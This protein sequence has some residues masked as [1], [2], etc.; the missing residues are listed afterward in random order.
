MLYGEGGWLAVEKPHKKGVWDQE[1]K[2]FTFI[3][4]KNL[5]LHLKVVENKINLRYLIYKFY[6]CCKYVFYFISMK[7]IRELSKKRVQFLF[8][9]HDL[10]NVNVRIERIKKSSEFFSFVSFFLH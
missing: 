2:K 1:W 10:E 6:S 4:K 7:K 9:L 3:S 8:Y 5:L